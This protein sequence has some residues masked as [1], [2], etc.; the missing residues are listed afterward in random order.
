VARL[1][2]TDTSGKASVE[3]LKQPIMWRCFV[4]LT[5]PMQAAFLD[6]G[7]DGQLAMALAYVEWFKRRANQRHGLNEEDVETALRELA[8]AFPS[9]TNA[10]GRAEAYQRLAVVFLKIAEVRHFYS[11]AISSG[12]LDEISSPGG[13]TSTGL[14]R[15]RWR[16]GFIVTFLVNSQERNENA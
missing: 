4:E 6:G 1:E 8:L 2:P 13:Q 5:E 14:F 3:I 9:V 16:H 7:S 15:W 12:L 10:N 11:E